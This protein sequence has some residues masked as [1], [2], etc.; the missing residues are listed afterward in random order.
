[1]LRWM[2]NN[3]FPP[4][5]YSR[6][7]QRTISYLL[8]VAS[9]LIDRLDAELLLAHVLDKPREFLI[10]HDDE[11]IGIVATWQFRKLVKKRKNGIPLAYLTGHKEFF[12][13]DFF[14]NKHTLVPRPDTELMV[15]EVLQE[16]KKTRNQEITLIDIGTGSGCI[17][18][19]I[20]TSI[21]QYNNITIFAADISKKALK[22]AKKNANKHNID[23][24]FKH[25]NLLAPLH[26]TFCILHSEIIITANLPYLTQTQFDEEPSIQH[27]PH[28]ALVADKQGLALYEELLEQI[29]TYHLTP[30]T[31]LEIDPTQTSQ[32]SAIITR[33]FP[34]ATI[35]IKKDLSGKDRVV[36]IIF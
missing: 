36:T 16:I 3:R 2:E 17:P 23:I 14:V 30:I 33:I 22:I 10:A 18:I 9:T 1:M 29:K 19:A 8:Q 12:G 7:M 20:A 35:E 27:E 32:I 25:G 6:T 31:Y 26:S 28:S 4:L 13:L 11:K 15:E 21:K 34:H 24:T 5:S